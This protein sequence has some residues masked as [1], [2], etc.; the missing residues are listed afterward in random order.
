MI[1][2]DKI[3]QL[4]KK[5]G[6]SQEE[7]A[8]RI[9]VSRQ[10]VSK[11]EGSLAVP[12]INK[13]IALSEVFG[14]S[15]DFLLKDS[16]EMP[17]DAPGE[18]ADAENTGREDSPLH[19]VSLETANLFLQNNEQNALFI[20]IG[21]M[22]CIISSVVLILT[23]S[24]AGIIFLLLCVGI[25]VMIFVSRGLKSEE[26]KFLEKEPLDTAYGVEGMVRERQKNY[27]GT[28]IREMTIGIGL[29]VISC[30]PLFILS[31]IMGEARETVGVAL[32][33]AFVGVGVFLIVKTSIIRSGYQVLLEEGNYTRKAK[34][35]SRQIGGIYWSAVTA[36]YLL[37]SFLTGRWDMTWIIWPVAG[38]VYGIL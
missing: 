33:L 23:E 38:V 37:I 13:I 18:A 29:C 25:G 36:A 24:L 30:L 27:S 8:D 34:Q 35:T 9:G 4:R 11:W 21:V 10:A 3:T 14:V 5:A 20:A 19:P 32:L 1:L 17:P 6:M 12:D 2:A 7:L 31:G 28:Y 16:A 26:F 22:L 15:T